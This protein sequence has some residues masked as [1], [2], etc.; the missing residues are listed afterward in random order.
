MLS[1]ERLSLCVR[2]AVPARFNLGRVVSRK[3]VKGSK[4]IW[5]DLRR[6]LEFG[7]PIGCRACLSAVCRSGP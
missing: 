2:S 6:S 4:G 7:L 1:L 3:S 5:A